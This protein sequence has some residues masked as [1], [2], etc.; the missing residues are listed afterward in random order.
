MMKKTLSVVTLLAAG[1]SHAAGFSFDTH[2]GRATG[3][4]FATT[5][6]TDDSTAIA[7]NVA[8]I[9]GVE[10]LDITVGD[11]TTLPKLSFTP[12]GGT[13]QQMG[14]TVV[15]PPHLFGVYRINDQMA[16]GLGI[17]V[18]FAA[19]SNWEEDFPFRTR[20]FYARLATYFINP[21][22]AYQAHERFRVGVG[23]NI[24]RGTVEI[25]RKI[26]FVD[27]EGTIEL[28]GGGWGLG[29][30]AGINVVVLD[31]L[32]DFA[33]TFRGPLKMKF[34]GKGDFQDVPAGFQGTLIDQ[35]ISS[36]VTLPGSANLGLGFTPL[37]NLTIALDAQLVLWSTFQDFGIE[38]ENPALTNIVAKNWKDTWNYRLGIEYGLTENFLVRLGASY[39]PIP[40]PEDTLTPDLPDAN[41]YK[42]SAGLGLKFDP[43]RADLGYQFVYLKDTKSTAAGF[44]GTYGGTG[45]VLGLTIGYAMK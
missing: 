32:L 18:P 34:K 13:K 24:V 43:I 29:Y 17:Y 39:D 3:M 40:S 9:L 20:G 7:F 21:S 22:F 12:E 37:K 19:G 41:R 36:T 35:P 10:K 25:T 16:A 5:A 26:N 31:K 8:N 15:P 1:L 14:T 33:A 6:V 44:E 42:A 38:F 23:L 2:S 45:H 27:T 28:G 11:V 4:S 30:N